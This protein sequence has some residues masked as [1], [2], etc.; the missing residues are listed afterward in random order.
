MDKKLQSLKSERA[1]RKGS[2][3]RTRRRA[4]VLVESRGSKREL[5]SM[6]KELDTALE[7]VLESNLKVKEELKDES[8]LLKCQEYGD[9]VTEEHKLAVEKVEAH[10]K[11]RSGE[12]PSGASSGSSAASR[13]A[14][15]QH[16]TRMAEVDDRVHKLELQQLQ[17]R[18]QKQEEEQRLN[19][20]RLLQEKEDAHAAAKLKAQLTKAAESDLSWDRKEDFNDEKSR[21]EDRRQK[22]TTASGKREVANEL[23]AQPFRHSLPRLKLPTFSG[24]VEEWPRWNVLFTTM[25]HNQDMSNSE[26]MVHLQNATTGAARAIIGGMVCDGS[27]YEDARQALEERFGRECD[28]VQA[29]L[30]TA[31]TCPAPRVNDSK[32]L[33]R[34]HGAV[35]GLTTTLKTMG[36]EGDLNSVENLR[37][38]A[39]KLPMDLRRAWAEH[40]LKIERTNLIHFDEWLGEQ[41]RV[42][43]NFE[44]IAATPASY[45][46]RTTGMFMTTATTRGRHCCVICNGDHGLW[47]CN[48]FKMKT[49]DERAQVVAANRLCFSCLRPNHQSRNCK[50]ARMCGID[51]CHLKH[52]QLLHGS[53]RV[54][55]PVPPSVPVAG[56]VGS[57]VNEATIA[58]V[59]KDTRDCS[60]TLLQV[61]PV[62]V[63][64]SGGRFKETLALLDPGAQTSLC[65]VSLLEE[66]QVDGE[67]RPLRLNSVESEGLERMSRRVQLELSPLAVTEDASKKICIP[68]AYSVD[69]VNVRVPVMKKKELQKMKHLQGLD[70]PDLCGEVQLLLGANVLEAVLQREARVGRPGEPVAIRTAFGWSLTGS[71][72]GVV[73]EHHR[74]VMF[75]SKSSPRQSEE[76]LSSMLQDWWSTESF[77][78][79]PTDN[80]ALAL[81]D[82]RAMEILKTTTRRR[83]G[84]YEVGLLWQEA[85][86]CMPDNYGMAYSRLESLERSLKRNPEKAAAYSEVL[87]GY[88]QQGYARKLTPQESQV[89]EHKRWILPHHAVL[90]PEK[91]KPRVVFDAAAESRGTSLNSKLLKGPDLLQNLHGVLL[92]FRQE[93]YALVAD[94]YQMFHQIRVRPEDQPAL[95]F[96]WRGLETTKPPD[97]FQMVVV[98]F[99][100]KCSPCIAN[101]VLRQILDE[102][103]KAAKLEERQTLAEEGKGDQSEE[104]NP[105]LVSSFYMDDFLRAEKSPE[106]AAVTMEEV[107][108]LLQRGGFRLTKWRSNLPELLENLP[109]EDRD[110]SQK[111][112]TSHEGG[113]RKA[114]G[115]LWSPTDDTMSIQVRSES[116]PATKRGI[117]KMAATIFD[118]LG[119]VSPF[120]LQAKII[121]QKL[122][123][124]KYDWDEEISGDELGLWQNWLA[125][126]DE[127]KN[128]KVPRCMK[129]TVAAN[130]KEMELHLFSDASEDAFGAV[131]YLR[132]TDDEGHRHVSF[133][134]SRTRV[135]PLKQL[136][137]VRLELQG[138]V[139]ATRLAKAIRRELTYKF[140]E[141]VFWSD[142]Q[143][144]LQF[145]TNE[146]RIFQT[147]VANRVSEIRDS[148]DPSQWRHVPGARNPA[149]ICSRGRSASQLRSS[150]LWWEGPEFLKRDR[151][152]WP[153]L[154]T[155]RLPPDQPELKRK[156]TKPVVSFVGG[157]ATCQSIV[158]PA[159]FSSWNKYRRIVAWILRFIRNA[160][161][162]EKRHGSL[163]VEELLQ[164]EQIIMREDQEREKIMPQPGLTLFR[165]ENGIVRVK[166]RL[167]NAPAEICRQPIVLTPGSDVT[168]LIVTEL[169]ERCMHAGLNHTLNLMREKFW[170]PKARASVKKLIWRCAHCRNRRAVQMTPKMADLPGERFDHTR[171][172]SSVGLDY[173]GPMTVRKFR[174]TE[175]RYILL[176]TCLATRAIHLEVAN[177]LDTDAWLSVAS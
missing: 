168:R 10:L 67:I 116:V 146:S 34:F 78:T 20:Q 75:V 137:I 23:D 6:L 5:R 79:K 161:T 27:S 56:A 121:I 150:D 176:V 51:D 136:S 132:M 106:A 16:A 42:L 147:F 102:E 135:A 49:V 144:V 84:R 52:S 1:L 43:L 155:P 152:D 53:K 9:E 29:T 87:E 13:A 97:L 37:R 86:V 44:A 134:M 30:R 104:G 158:D 39:S 126:L 88:V 130:I 125:E 171:P 139:L 12:A 57:S 91:Q 92:R 159:R 76:D 40:S 50:T 72:A 66:L 120:L 123:A 166:G 100:A 18:L 107:K 15:A 96:L 48:Q 154:K 24:N 170:M 25:V 71:L 28:V 33:E 122:W 165:D 99:G 55:R 41:V 117:V 83:E 163:T 162:K 19:R 38:L 36:Y 169:H 148:T 101:Y 7:Q 81:E 63:H 77:G 80:C 110:S 98:I 4:L 167:K 60:S 172:F 143:V 46:K 174:K 47:L 89:K 95:S 129:M 2:L 111:K 157:A 31:F 160:R 61:V 145:V 164:A 94:I 128:I 85:E 70:I 127:V 82:E 124:R 115:C 73:P 103:D 153:C 149:D 105:A 114:L 90:H 133:V 65:S 58:S 74:E 177:S 69:R 21:E 156:A 108:S 151:R 14:S 140:D 141:V 131:A 119:F 45:Q 3:T 59:R 17:R 32:S 175:K 142:S 93:Q 26:K 54:R 11:E 62:R 64:G 8:E 118:P 138:A 22:D 109:E 113:A 35:H 112:L 173:L 68:E